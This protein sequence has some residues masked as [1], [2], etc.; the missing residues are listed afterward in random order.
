MSNEKPAGKLPDKSL[1]LP[2]A[3]KRDRA[4]FEVLRIWIAEKGQHVSL[5]SGAWEDPFAWGIVLADLAR[6]VANAHSIQ[7]PEVDKEVFLDR[8]LEGFEA[9]IANPTDD[10]EGE[11]TQ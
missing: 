3:A 7:N 2:P 1:D 10:P 6:H 4:S 9:E 11:V 5:R 8:L